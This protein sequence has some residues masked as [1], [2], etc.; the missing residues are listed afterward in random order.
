MAA[1][2][3]VRNEGATVSRPGHSVTPVRVP[4]LSLAPIKSASIVAI[5]STAW[6][7]YVL[8]RSA[9]ASLVSRFALLILV[10]SPGLSLAG[11]GT[12]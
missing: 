12:G 10:A 4:P 9:S 11:G 5:D 2:I 7:I 1:Y 6:L 8:W 3:C